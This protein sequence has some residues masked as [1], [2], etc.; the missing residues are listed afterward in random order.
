MLFQKY[1]SLVARGLYPVKSYPGIPQPTPPELKEQAIP[2]V[3]KAKRLNGAIQQLQDVAN[4]LKGV[5]FAIYHIPGKH[6]ADELLKLVKKGGSIPT[7]PVWIDQS[8]MK[9][10]DLLVDYSV[11]E[12]LVKKNLNDRI[13]LKAFTIND[14]VA[15]ARSLISSKIGKMYAVHHI[16]GD[17]PIEELEDIAGGNRSGIVR[18]VWFDEDEALSS[19]SFK[20][21]M[22][23]LDHS[24]AM[25]EAEFFSVRLLHDL[26][27]PES[28]GVIIPPLRP[29]YGNF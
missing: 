4:A 17:Y 1:F 16:I 22:E 26:A 20:E 12:G 9:V 6:T 29:G 13:K 10:Y 8:K 25:T 7:T 28:P 19:L 11:S 27:G 2:Y 14:A 21:I 5:T 18:L 23:A 3:A 24:E 15:V